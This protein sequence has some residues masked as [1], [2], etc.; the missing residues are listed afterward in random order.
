MADR[1]AGCEWAAWRKP[2]GRPP[3][4]RAWI[5]SWMLAVTG[6]SSGAAEPPPVELGAVRWQRD[7]G[8]A[9][10]ASRSDGRPV[11][12]LFQEVPG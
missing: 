10:A 1:R 2:A 3:S 11:M 9:L 6:L 7:P 12:L 5:G 4:W 8:A